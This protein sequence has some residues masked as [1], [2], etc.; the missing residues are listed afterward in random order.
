MIEKSLAG[1]RYSRLTQALYQG[2]VPK[3]GFIIYTL[4][5]KLSLLHQDEGRICATQLQDNNERNNAWSLPRSSDM[6]HPWRARQLFA[7]E[8]RN[9][10][11]WVGISGV[12]PLKDV[13]PTLNALEGVERILPSAL[14]RW[15]NVARSCKRV[16]NACTETKECKNRFAAIDDG[17]ICT[18]TGWLTSAL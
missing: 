10:L 18:S 1:N 8:R 5:L 3:T 16:S 14:C 12:F 11:F 15:R 4:F 9:D 7:D 2:P 13:V 6:V 17:S